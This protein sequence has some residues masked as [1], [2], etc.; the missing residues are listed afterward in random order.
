MG[1]I[2]NL[3]EIVVGDKRKGN[4]KYDHFGGCK[5]DDVII[6]ID[7][8][9]KGKEMYFFYYYFNFLLLVRWVSKHHQEA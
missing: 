7:E 6:G 2:S 8:E 1:C 5:W 3:K 4:D 9:S